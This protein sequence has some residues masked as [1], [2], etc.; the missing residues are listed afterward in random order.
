M[1]LRTLCVVRAVS[2]SFVSPVM[3]SH[4]KAPP[5]M[6]EVGTSRA[7]IASSFVSSVRSGEAAA[8]DAPEE[9]RRRPADWTMAGKLRTRRVRRRKAGLR[10]AERRPGASPGSRR[11]ALLR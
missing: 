2:K 6:P 5:H 8:G 3:G 7:Q 10:F 9:A 1:R 11:P 4:R